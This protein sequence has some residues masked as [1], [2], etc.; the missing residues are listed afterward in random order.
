MM[1]VM[2]MKKIGR[3]V[4][5]L[6]AVDGN[7]RNGE[8]AFIRLNNNAIMFA[9]TRFIGS[10]WADDCEADIAALFSY[11]EGET[12]GDE[13]ILFYHDENSRNLMEPNFIRM[14][15]GDLGIVYLRK[16]KGSENGV[17]YFARS[18]DEGKTFSQPQR[19]IDD[20][21]NY[22]VLENDHVVK[23]RNGRILM[24][25]NLHSV[26]TDKG[27]EVIEHG[28]KCI[29]ASDDDGRSWKEIAQRQDIPFPHR[30]ETGLQETALYEQ[31][32]GK[33]RA[34]SRTDMAFQYEC[35]SFDGGETWT[36]PE[37]NR[38]FSSPDSPLLMK[39]CGKYTV[40]I[41]NPIPNYTTR[42]DV[43][44]GRTPF[45]MGVSEDDGKT[46]ERM[47]FLED[48][49][50]NGYCYPAIFSGE[51]YILVSYYHSN[52]TGIPLNSNKIIKIR[53][54]ELT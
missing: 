30:S 27:I 40:V 54:D 48:D 22:F 49:P 15:N 50:D 6:K 3:E 33:I 38:F 20:N 9:Y 47:Y 45:V 31:K 25:A 4:L 17:P 26:E 34:F 21:D 44:W 43:A 24:P 19:V 36:E 53:Y 13:R 23:L 29:F 10:D 11:D 35:F 51:D 37:P 42:P 7:P 39:R 14:N 52:D 32:D 41:F 28:L 1:W 18:A 2:N 16:A 5:F 8:G 46:F 12:W